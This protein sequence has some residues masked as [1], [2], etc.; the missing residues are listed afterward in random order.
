M[1]NLPNSGGRC[2]RRRVLVRHAAYTESGRSFPRWIGLEGSQR[3]WVCLPLFHINAQAYSLMTALAHGFAV[4]LSPKFH[5]TTFWRD[6]RTLEVTSVNVVGAMLEFLAAQVANQPLPVGFLEPILFRC[7]L[8]G[9][10]ARE[11]FADRRSL[12]WPPR[13]P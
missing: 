2:L 12:A 11:T 9:R 3:L 6:A 8:L 5:A 1:E 4:A 10:F 13:R 7:L